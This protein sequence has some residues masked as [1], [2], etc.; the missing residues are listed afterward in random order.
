MSPGGSA[1]VSSSARKGVSGPRTNRPETAAPA[2]PPMQEILPHPLCH[3]RELGS[4]DGGEGFK[5][6]GRDIERVQ[7]S[8]EEGLAI[9]KAMDKAVK[10]LVERDHAAH[11]ATTPLRRSKFR[12]APGTSALRRMSRATELTSSSGSGATAKRQRTGQLPRP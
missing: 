7:V 11:L 1:E 6:L 9:R 5:V 12:T 8:L 10:R 4:I 2:V 3:P